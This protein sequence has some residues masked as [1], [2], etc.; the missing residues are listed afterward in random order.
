MKNRTSLVSGMALFLCFALLT[1]ADRLLLMFPQFN[2][3]FLLMLIEIVIFAIP[4][5]VLWYGTGRTSSI[6]WR[7]SLKVSQPAVLIFPI[8]S[9]LAVSLIGFLLYSPF[10]GGQVAPLPFLGKLYLHSAA[11]PA[12]ASTILFL[13]VSA[14]AQEL[15]LRGA[16]FSLHESIGGARFSILLSGIYFAILPGSMDNF[17]ECLLAGLL[18][19][20]L[21]YAFDS[22]WPAILAHFTVNGFHLILLWIVDTYAVFGIWKYLLTASV[23]LLLLF[24]YISLCGIESLILNDRITRS[25]SP[26]VHNNAMLSLFVN[27]GGIAFVLAFV[28][29]ALF[30]IL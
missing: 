24:I 20:Y 13:V 18:Y 11:T 22:I 21:T 4:L 25:V 30:R 10:H 27:P 19:A 15:F 9:A 26:A 3:A 6:R 1:G 17:L 23:V 14:I 29:K 7:L 2:S 12:L 5:L 8:C 28:L 16:L